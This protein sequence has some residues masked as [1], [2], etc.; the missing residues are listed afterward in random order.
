MNVVLLQRVDRWA[1]VPLCWTL[2]AVRKLFGREPPNSMQ[3]PRN[4]LFVKLAEQGSTVLAYAALKRAV[5]MAGRE[6][7]HFVA[8]EANRFILDVL[9]IIPRENVITVSVKGLPAFVRTMMV[10]L[11]RIRAL[12]LEAA[13]DLEFFSRGSAALTFL[14]GAKRRAGF[15]SF[16]GDG[17]YRGD[18]MTHR[19]LYNPHLHTSQTFL[20]LVDAL[21]CDAKLLPTSDLVPVASPAQ[22]AQ[23]A[24]KPDDRAAVERI[25]YGR[26]MD[27]PPLILLNPNASDLIPLRRWRPECYVELAQRLLA[28]YPE[29]IVGL[30][31]APYESATAG[32]LVGRIGSE[33]CV[34]FAGKTTLHQLLILYTLAD[35]LVTNDSGPAHFATLTPVEVVT[36]FGPET[37]A[38]FAARTPRNTVLWAG[39]ACSPCVSAYNNRLSH[40][41][42]NRCMQAITID[43]VFAAVCRAYEKKAAER[44]TLSVCS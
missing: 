20:S 26:S 30:T 15:H 10:A 3:A 33:R 11:R 25:V 1:G 39:L 4:I 23:I 42:D 13:V 28:K 21:C 38:L 32:A 5:E 40:C 19:L 14:S 17:P 36:L 6:N 44:K 41:R 37:P 18:L 43:Q 22:A 12:R 9:G 7:V 29:I 34:S 31:G 35:V 27:R 16:F 2:T 8:F 24:F